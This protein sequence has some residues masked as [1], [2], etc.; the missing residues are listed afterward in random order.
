MRRGAAWLLCAWV[1]I[2][3]QIPP[4]AGTWD[5]LWWSVWNRNTWEVIASF[6]NQASCERVANLH[7]RSVSVQTGE[8][9]AKRTLR[10]IE[11]DARVR[12]TRCLPT[13]LLPTI[14]G[15]IVSP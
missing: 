6:D 8:P 9:R 4:E 2:Q 15:K 5:R 11:Y 14:E 3:P 13:S 7:T 10:E 12:Q 1:V